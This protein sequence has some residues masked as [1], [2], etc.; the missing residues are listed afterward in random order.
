MKRGRKTKLT[1]TLQRQLCK[2]IAM[3]CTIRSACQ[4]CNLAESTFNDWV[5]RGE[6]GEPLFSEFAAAVM[7]ARGIGK[8]KIAQSILDSDDVRVKLEYLARVY[9]DEF[10]RREIV[11]LPPQPPRPPPDLSKSIRFT[12]HGAPDVDLRQFMELKAKLE[13]AGIKTDFPIRDQPP[14]QATPAADGEVFA[15][16]LDEF[17]N[18]SPR[19]GP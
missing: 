7:R 10:G 11:P 17:G 3:P 19:I 9:P 14:A 15:G 6:A 18:G 2:I 12:C 5:R 4:S 8:V 16:N 13:A 1:K